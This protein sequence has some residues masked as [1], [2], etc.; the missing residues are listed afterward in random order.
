MPVLFGEG[1]QVWRELETEAS[2]RFRHME[3]IEVI[4][5]PPMWRCVAGWAAFHLC[6]GPFHEVDQ[7]CWKPVDS[8]MSPSSSNWLYTKRKYI[9]GEI[10]ALVYS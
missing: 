5:I 4:S 1:K 8:T 7:R 10:Y 3:A 9:F 2:S 6:R